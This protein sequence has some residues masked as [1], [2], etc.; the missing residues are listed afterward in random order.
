[1]KKFSF[2]TKFDLGDTIF[3]ISHTTTR[4]IEAKVVEILF[5]VDAKNT[6]VYYKTDP[7]GMEN[8]NRCFASREELM[9]QL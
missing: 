6:T 7:C 2:Q 8:E 1:M 9:K 3:F 5:F 4:I